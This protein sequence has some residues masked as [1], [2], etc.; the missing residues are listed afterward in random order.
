MKQ[1]ETIFGAPPQ[2]FEGPGPIVKVN[3]FVEPLV[4]PLCPQ[5]RHVPAVSAV[6]ADPNRPGLL[7]N[8]GNDAA[9]ILPEKA[10]QHLCSGLYPSLLKGL[11]PFA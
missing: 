10:S 11:V 5:L 4:H 1:M 7:E 6:F 8:G 2:F 3:Q 9:H